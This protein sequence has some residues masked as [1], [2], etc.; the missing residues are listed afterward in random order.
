MEPQGC[1]DKK[2]CKRISCLGIAAV[3]LLAAFAFVVGL[4]VAAQTGII[5][6]LTVPVI[7]A[8]TIILGLLLIISIILLIC[9]KVRKC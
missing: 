7:V 2:S 3:I 1:Y 4:L 5:A 8:L 6:F 9:K